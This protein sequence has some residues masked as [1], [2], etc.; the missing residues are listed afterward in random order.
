MSTLNVY[1]ASPGFEMDDQVISDRPNVRTGILTTQHEAAEEGAP[2]V[3]EE[4]TA[5][6]YRPG[7]LPPD[8]VLY[9][10]AAPGGLPP[11]AKLAKEAGFK[12]RHA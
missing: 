8:T 5:R 7:D 12:V 6:V 1:W 10:E 4:V 11:L 2:V 3:V 9:V